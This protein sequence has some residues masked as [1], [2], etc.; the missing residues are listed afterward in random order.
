MEIRKCTVAEAEIVGE[1]YDG[2]VKFMNDNNVNYT[3]WLYKIFP[4]T[5]YAVDAARAGTQF[6]CTDGEKIL[7]AFVLNENPEG[8]YSKVAWSQNLAV[9]EFLVL[10]ALAIAPDC[11]RRGLGKKF[12]DF[13]ASYA[14]E[15]NYRAL[16]LD[17]VPTNFP[18]KKLY[19]ACGFKFVGAAD[20]GRTFLGIPQFCLYERNL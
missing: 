15:K 1:F 6:V 17:V 3:K 16:R 19:E 12:M 10:H 9:G 13:C 8:D 7:A 4:T 2:V 20:L 5:S 11:Q 14:V 18:A